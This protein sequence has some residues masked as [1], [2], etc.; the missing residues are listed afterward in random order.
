MA[1]C[2]FLSFDVP[3]VHYNILFC[4]EIFFSLS[5]FMIN[6]PGRLRKI[7]HFFKKICIILGV[8]SH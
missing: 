3:K 4:T 7:M 2:R 1:W 5:G 8:I 6:L